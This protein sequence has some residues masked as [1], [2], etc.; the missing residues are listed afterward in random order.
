MQIQRI[1]NLFED[2]FFFKKSKLNILD[3][4]IIPQALAQG[5]SEEIA[6]NYSIVLLGK[7]QV[8]HRIDETLDESLY[9]LTLQ[10]GFVRLS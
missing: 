3:Q 1:I 4:L 9:I 8:P 7:T 2:Y 10:T 6:K 5:V